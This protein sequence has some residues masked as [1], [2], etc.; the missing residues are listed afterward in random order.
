MLQGRIFHRKHGCMLRAAA[1]QPHPRSLAERLP[2][3]GATVLRNVGK[4]TSAMM[5]ESTSIRIGGLEYWREISTQRTH[6]TPPTTTHIL[7]LHGPMRT[8]RRS[9]LSAT[10]ASYSKIEICACTY[11]VVQL[12]RLNTVTT[13]YR[14]PNTTISNIDKLKSSNR[15][16]NTGNNTGPC[17]KKNRNA[18][19]AKSSWSGPQLFGNSRRL[20]PRTFQPLRLGERYRAGS[21]RT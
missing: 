17:G 8:R 10:S 1:T 21:F 12:V 14:A 11:T 13:S 18:R 7:H 2:A 5:I 15:S 20:A 6:S 16:S 3:M 19:H 9:K 4:C